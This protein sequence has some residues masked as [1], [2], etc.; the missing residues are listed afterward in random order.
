MPRNRVADLLA[1][2][3][4]SPGCTGAWYGYS[5]AEPSASFIR[6]AKYGARPRQ[7]RELGR[8]FAA[9]LMAD[10]PAALQA[11]ACPVTDADVL[12]PVPM[13]RMKLMRRGYNQAEEIARG[14][15]D[16]T[17]VPVGDNL[18]AVASHSTQTALG[19]EARRRN[20]YGC[21]ALRYPDEIE[22]LHVVIVDDIITTGSTIMECAM[23]IGRGNGRPRAI[24]ALSL[25]LAG[26]S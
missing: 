14:I 15:S 16:V 19:M 23:A 17:G 6:Q 21:Y 3:V 8:L 5:P 13:H 22:G 9:E 12:L 20:I 24:G 4:A 11:G 7:C 25:G 18:V 26:N 2:A 10:I 1:N